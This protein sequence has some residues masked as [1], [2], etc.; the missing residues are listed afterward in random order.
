MGIKYS[1]GLLK[2]DHTYIAQHLSEVT[3]CLKHREICRP[4]L[5]SSKGFSMVSHVMLSCKIHD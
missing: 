5:D 3:D 2:A 1:M 4:N